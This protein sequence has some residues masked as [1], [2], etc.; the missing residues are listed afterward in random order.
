LKG[1]YKWE[2][3]QL[4]T[5]SGSDRTRGNDYKLK[6]GKF[7]LDIRQKILTQRA[8]MP[9]HSCPEKLWCP[10]PGGAQGHAGWAL[11]SLS[12][13]VA[14]SPL[15]EFGTGWPLSPFK[16]KPLYNSMKKVCK[17]FCLRS[18]RSCEAMVGMTTGHAHEEQ[19]EN[20]TFSN[21]DL[22]NIGCTQSNNLFFLSVLAAALPSPYFLS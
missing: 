19:Q 20:P 2:G 11:G 12:W 4:L 22:E 1:A 5:Q 16:P 14:T 10:N 7:R 8:V 9:W 21:L 15:Q 3:E 17:W 6:E 13:W 18:C